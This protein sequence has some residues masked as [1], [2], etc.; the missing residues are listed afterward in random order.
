MGE[1]DAVVV[2]SGPNGLAAAV[3]LAR[4]GL[5][6][7]VLEAA[8]TI[9]GG[10]RTEELT[11]PG[12]LHDD[13][14]AVHP[15]GVAS[16]F[17]RACKLER[18]GLEWVQP[19][20]PLV[21]PVD[22]ERRGV[23]H[24]SL[25]ETAAGLGVDAER[26]RSLMAPFVKRWKALAGDILTPVTHV[27]P[28]HPLLLARFGLHSLRSAAGLARARFETD[29]AQAL[30]AGMAAH[31]ILPM[32]RPLTAS[33]GLVLGVAAHGSGWPIAQGG[34]R[35]IT[36]ALA[37]YLRELGGEIE[38]DRPVRSL[39]DMPAARARLFDVTPRQLIA[40]AGA[41]LPAS[42]RGRLERFRRGA[43]VFKVDYA[44]SGPIP[45]RAAEAHRAGTVHL[46]G[47]LA[48]VMA[49]EH[50]VGQGRA[51]EV[52]FVLVVQ[53]SVFDASRAPAGKHTGWAYCHVPYGCNEDMTARLERQIERFAPGFG[54]LVLARRVRNPEALAAYNEN[55]VGGDI[56]GG[57][58]DGLQ[59][60]MR[61]LV[62]LDPYRVPLRGTYLCSS[63]TPPGAGVHG[64]C[65]Y[66]AAR[67]A[68]KHTF[69]N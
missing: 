26:Y 44:L 6:V 18:Y 24:H 17:F 15:L 47:T 60:F 27:P 1:L 43:G 38:C 7:R 14:S 53:Q 10:T 9:G 4:Q 42:Y 13:C 35:S 66:W 16:P 2:G 32:D 12:F 46:G 64:M 57:A 36:D 51:P 23:L 48:E 19:D 40:I 54:E 3:T 11:L 22:D 29:E 68:L 62:S 34:S 45:W 59:L 49:A 37:A 31:A 63:S 69:R 41:E 8:G 65:G 20:Y 67:S 50:A 33:F 58:H 28:R 21:H 56:A 5:A 30:F 61:P 39:R 25:E 52:P 55:Y